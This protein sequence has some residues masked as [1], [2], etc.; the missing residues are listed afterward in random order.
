MYLIALFH[1]RKSH[2]WYQI[3]TKDWYQMVHLV[4]LDRENCTDFPKT[5]HRFLSV[6][7]WWVNSCTFTLI[8]HSTSAASSPIPTYFKSTV[9]CQSSSTFTKFW[10]VETDGAGAAVDGFITGGEGSHGRKNGSGHWWFLHPW[11]EKT[12]CFNVKW[13]KLAASFNDGISQKYNYN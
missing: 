10:L 5:S 3:G 8:L 7:Q 12:C 11:V 9:S 4:L 1:M 6:D 13:N 2:I